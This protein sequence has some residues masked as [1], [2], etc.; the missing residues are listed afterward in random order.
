M[1]L[2]DQCKSKTNLVHLYICFLFS[3]S[4]GT[5][6]VSFYTDTT[7]M[8]IRLAGGDKHGL[9]ICEVQPNSVAQKAGLLVADKIFSVS[10]SMKM[11]IIDNMT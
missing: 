11:M 6:Y 5:R 8:G 7:S 9:F 2:S 3:Y 4:T 1:I 10:I